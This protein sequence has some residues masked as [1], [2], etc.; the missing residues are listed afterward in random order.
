MRHL[1]GFSSLS[2]DLTFCFTVWNRF[3]RGP[4]IFKIFT[5]ATKECV[6]SQLLCHSTICFVLVCVYVRQFW[7]LWS[8]FY[9]Q[10]HVWSGFLWIWVTWTIG[11]DYGSPASSH[12]F[13]SP[14]IICLF[15]LNET[16]INIL[17]WSNQIN[18]FWFIIQL[19]WPIVLI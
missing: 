11:K 6:L 13:T 14:S 3:N 12:T 4:R 8:M 5:T 10:I 9:L 18:C 16:S 2:V 7:I 1:Y 15:S 19:Q 17:V